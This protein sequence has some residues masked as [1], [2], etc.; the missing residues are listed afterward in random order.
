MEEI[1]RLQHSCRGHRAHLTKVI[2]KAAKIMESDSPN[3]MEIASLNSI[4]EQLA[5]KR[6]VLNGLNEK[7]STMIE[8][9]EEL[10]QEI[11]KTDDIDGDIIE[12]SIQISTF[13]LSVS[14]KNLSKEPPHPEI[15]ISAIQ[16]PPVATP[17]PSVTS[18]KGK[19]PTIELHAINATPE[20]I[21]GGPNTSAS[22]PQANAFP[23]TN[24]NSRLSKLN[25][26]TFSG[27]PLNWLTFWDSFNVTINSN[28]NL[29]GIQKFNYLRAQLTGDAARAIAGFPL[30]NNNYEP[31]VDLLKERFG[32]PQRIINAHMQALLELSSPTNKLSSIQHFHDSMENHVRGLTS[33]GKSN[34][35]YGDL[36]VPIILGKLP[37]DIRRN[38]TRE[39]ITAEWPFN[40]LRDFITKEIRIMEAGIHH[41]SGKVP[42]TQP[43]SSVTASFHM[44][45]RGVPQHT[46]RPH[47]SDTRRKCAYCKGPHPSNDCHVTTDYQQRWIIVKG[48]L[49]FNCLGHHKASACQSKNCCRQCK[50]KHHTSLC[51]NYAKGISDTAPTLTVENSKSS[52]HTTLAPI[53]TLSVPTNAI[54]LLKTAI[55]TVGAHHTYCEANIHFDEG[56]QRSSTQS[57][58]NQLNLQP[59]GT[60]TISLSAFG[61]Q[62]SAR[63]SLNTTTINVV[64]ETNDQIPVH[65]LAGDQ[66]SVYE[67][68]KEQFI[69]SPEGW[70]ETSLPWKGSHPSLPN[71]ETGSL[72]RLNNLVKK[73]EKQPN[74]LERYNNIIRDQLAQRIVERV[75]MK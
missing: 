63:K 49:C 9:P 58:A 31:A 46:K 40:Q 70:Y 56:A 28:P 22:P 27:N 1:Q 2:N 18:H 23:N 45:T 15:P 24:H 51:T 16:N 39:H 21:S 19:L 33:L 20:N 57:L 41:S 29:E 26:P 32:Q 34:E 4:I 69:R 55:A 74:M 10:E 71:N 3:E 75:G 6:T 66:T 54:S 13:I 52:V 37:T 11:F 53:S 72:K 17:Q 12:Q 5:K 68:F 8:E 60:E 65:V 59:T 30:T 43:S 25:L 61:A 42:S 67:E 7:I 38:L 64:T 47:V 48:G 36:L 73:L 44:Q 62:T 14:A 35:S 50:G